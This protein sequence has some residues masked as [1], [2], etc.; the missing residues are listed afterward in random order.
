MTLAAA[1]SGTLDPN[2]PADAALLAL[3]ATMAV[4]DAS[5]DEAEVEFLL[6]ILP[7]RDRDALVAWA[8]DVGSAAQRPSPQ[9]VA[10]AV[11]A[12]DE[13]WR[14]LRFVARMAWKDGSVAPAEEALLG[15]L[16]SAFALPPGAVARVLHEMRPVE[17]MDATRIKAT[18]EEVRWNAAQ[19]AEGALVSVDL[20]G[21]LPRGAEVVVRVGLDM[22]ELMALCTTGVVARFQEGPAFVPWADLVAITRGAA[23]G[24]AIRL[25]LEDGSSYALVDSRLS[26]LVLVVDRLRGSGEPRKASG[27]TVTRVG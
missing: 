23:L 8:R 5:V 1:A 4:S 22:V 11:E 2:R 25:H 20:I 16:A 18:V 13:R 15:A 12:P 10:D 9:T 27:V 17:A 24:E 6:R 3:L 14:A 19:F 21:V 7:G 26:G